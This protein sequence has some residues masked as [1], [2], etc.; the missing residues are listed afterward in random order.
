MTSSLLIVANDKSGNLV[1]IGVDLT[2]P[3]QGILMLERW[4]VGVPG[5]PSQASH[6]DTREASSIHLAPDR[7]SIS[8]KVMGIWVTCLL[9]DLAAATK[10]VTLRYGVFW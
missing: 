4:N 1:H 6:T 9:G 10:T 3:D 5:P 8:F 2:G 7:Q